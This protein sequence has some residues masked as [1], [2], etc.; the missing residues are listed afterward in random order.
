MH[1]PVTVNLSCSLQVY[2]TIYHSKRSKQSQKQPIM[3][4]QILKDKQDMAESAPN[5]IQCDISS[6]TCIRNYRSDEALAFDTL[7]FA[8]LPAVLVRLRPHEYVPDSQH[9]KVF[10]LVC[11]LGIVVSLENETAEGFAAT[12][13]KSYKY[14]S[15]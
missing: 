6:S 9:T 15:S 11:L 8:A 3:S 7:P 12:V 13:F 1:F 2:T 10:F 4:R 14:H 5:T